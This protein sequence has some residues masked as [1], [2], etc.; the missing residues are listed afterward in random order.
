MRYRYEVFSQVAF[1][2]RFSIEHKW[3]FLE[4]AITKMIKVGTAVREQ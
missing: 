4:A 2:T 3:H 1:L